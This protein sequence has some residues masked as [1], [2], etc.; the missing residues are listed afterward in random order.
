MLTRLV[1]DV[2]FGRIRLLPLV[3]LAGYL[4]LGWV[5][6]AAADWR[7]LPL[8]GVAVLVF[9]GAWPLPVALAEVTLF[10]FVSP[11]SGSTW[12]M[13][14][15]LASVALVELAVRRP[16]WQAGIAGLA[17]S[18]AYLVNESFVRSVDVF[19]WEG[20]GV[21]IPILLGAWLRLVLLRNKDR[22][23]RDLRR[24]RQAERTE[25]AREL[26]DLV[27]HHVA[28]MAL[29]AGIA[30]AVVPDLDPR[31]GAVLDDVHSSARTALTDLRRLVGVLR[32]PATS[33]TR[34]EHVDPADLPAAVTAVIDRGARAGIEVE[35]QVDPV[36][37]T[38]DSVH[39]LAVLRL[40]QEGLT[41]VAKHAAGARTT[42]LVN[43]VDGETR[44]EVTDDGGGPGP[45]PVTESGYGLIGLRERVEVLGGTLTAGPHGKGW[46]LHATL[47]SVDR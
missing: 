32:D 21:V 20:G 13:V 27:A 11:Q 28:S 30:R 17:L 42:V 35:L 38:L 41:N 39:G 46:R 7:V 44:V 5:F 45:L 14:G 10:A 40:V 2:Q 33:G 9:G 23:L 19:L 37:A 47:P 18:L 36:I 3:L 8:V 34:V 43:L 29:R 1:L 15:V 22:H 12:V 31:I 24:A 25:I 26:H 6:D 16:L 4:L